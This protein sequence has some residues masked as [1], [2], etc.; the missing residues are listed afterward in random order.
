MDKFSSESLKKVLITQS[1]HDTIDSL[2]GYPVDFI[3]EY[4]GEGI[5]LFKFMQKVVNDL[6]SVDP[7]PEAVTNKQIVDSLIANYNSNQQ[8]AQVLAENFL[9]RRKDVQNYLSNKI[10]SEYSLYSFN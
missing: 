6:M 10:L 9:I 7:K 3:S 1:L 8:T 4:E 5:Q 2:C